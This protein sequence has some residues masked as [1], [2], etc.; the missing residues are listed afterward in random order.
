MQLVELRVGRVLGSPHTHLPLPVL[1][2]TVLPSTV[3][4]CTNDEV[5]DGCRGQDARRQGDQLRC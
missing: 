5:E 1:S 2:I 4:G 3:V